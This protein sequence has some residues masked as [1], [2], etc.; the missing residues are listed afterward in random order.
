[1]GDEI[2]LRMFLYSEYEMM[3]SEKI[4]VKFEVID[5][6]DKKNSLEVLRINNF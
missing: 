3:Q 5:N 4:E 1:M 6:K 2:D